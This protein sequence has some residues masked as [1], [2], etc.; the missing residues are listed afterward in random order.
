MPAIL[1][2]V[3]AAAW[4]WIA[5]FGVA[6]AFG[7]Y[8]YVEGIEHQRTIDEAAQEQA[9]VAAA[10]LTLAEATATT[11][12]MNAYEAQIAYLQSVPPQVVQSNVVRYLHGLCSA[13]PSGSPTVPSSSGGSAG[14]TTADTAIRPTDLE[15]DIEAAEHNAAALKLCSGWVK[16]NGGT[17]Q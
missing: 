16:D 13:A 14:S 5:I 17:A 8:S 15:H 12:R 11:K 3:P 2:L 4:R 9:A 7:A 6:L 10:K 1:A